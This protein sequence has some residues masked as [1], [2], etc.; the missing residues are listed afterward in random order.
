MRDDGWGGPAVRG[1]V[2]YYLTGLVVLA[3]AWF[4]TDFLSRQ[5]HPRQNPSGGLNALTAWDGTWYARIARDG[6]SYDPDE[7]SPVA[8][9]PAYPLLA[10]GVMAATGLRAEAAL[11]AVSHGCLLAAFVVLARYVAVRSA[12]GRPGDGPDL[13]DFVLLSFG[14]WPTA[15]F[16]RAA[17]TESLFVLVCLT[18]FYGI[19]RR[20]PPVAVAAVVGLATAC[21]PVGMALLIPFLFSLRDVSSS[22]AG[23]LTRAAVYGPVACWGIASYVAYL[24]TAF[25]EPFAFVLTQRHWTMRPPAAAGESLAGLFLLRPLWSVYV[26]SSPAYWAEF[27]PVANPLFSLQFA[28][29]LF[30]VATAGLVAFGARRG[31]LT[32]PEWAFAAALLAIPYVTHA[33]RAVMMAQGRYAASAFPV[34]LVLGRIAARSPAPLVA[35]VAAVLTAAYAALF[36]AWYRII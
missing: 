2:Y 4:G 30:V 22:A 36:A 15:M 31:W 17:Y 16:C 25:G 19:A 21:R 14:L 24:G 10:R 27:E 8:F 29:P 33:E 35:A 34:Y 7:A 11:L 6:Y 20:W 26:P 23:F 13:P 9:F 12:D 5:S 1:G 18:A 3:G 28:N 32:T